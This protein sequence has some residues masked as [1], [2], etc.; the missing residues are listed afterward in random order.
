MNV[1][2]D[3]LMPCIPNAHWR[4]RQSSHMFVDPETPL[5]VLH[6]FASSIGLKRAWFQHRRG[7][8]P[9]YDLTPSRRSVAVRRGAIEV[10]RRMI[11]EA[12]RAWRAAQTQRERRA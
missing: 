9:H 2:V 8:M 12:I 6:E 4:W 3:P 10:D 11:A 1:Y 7:G 5:D